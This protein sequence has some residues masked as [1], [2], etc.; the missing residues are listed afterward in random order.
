M[1]LG[2]DSWSLAPIPGSSQPRHVAF[3]PRLMVNAVE[4]A[5]DSAVAGYGPTMVFSYQ[6]A[7]HV[8]AGRLQIVLPEAEPP[9]RP[10]HLVMPEGRL[11]VPKVR[12]FVDFAVP[13]LKA[14]FA[15]LATL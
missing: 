5:V 10:V 14:R 11:S 9:P 2:Q 4:A 1:T 12:A 7:E 3:A 6:V 13:P 8:R 15:D